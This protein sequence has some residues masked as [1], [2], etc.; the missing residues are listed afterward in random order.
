MRKVNKI[1]MAIVAILLTLVLISTSLVSGIFARFVVTKQAST[2][3]SLERFGV[4]LKLT[5]N[6]N[7]KSTEQ[8]LSQAGDTISVQ[9][10]SDLL[11]GDTVYDALKVEVTGTPNVKVKFRMTCTVEYDWN[12][13]YKVS[14]N[15][16]Y[17][18]AAGN[19]YMPLGYTIG[20][21]K[22]DNGKIT[23]WQY[24]CRPYQN[25]TQSKIEEIIIRNTAK[26]LE[27]GLNFDTDGSE[28]PKVEVSSGNYD[29]YFEKEFSSEIT[30]KINCFYM[31]FDW[32]GS[33]VYNKKTYPTEDEATN[34]LIATYFSEQNSPIQFKYTF[35]IEQAD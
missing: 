1:L 35:H 22:D 15:S 4:E 33:V 16:I 20:F 31:G 32:L 10:T 26:N 24:V 8:K 18:T 19:Y 30:G 6:A 29:Y 13:V 5:P 11:M 3:V 28:T 12:G 2:V 17:G 9:F 34:N 25:R 7:L 23:D 14:D 21:N 27:L